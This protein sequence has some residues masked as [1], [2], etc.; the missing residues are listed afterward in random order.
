MTMAARTAGTPIKKLIIICTGGSVHL[1]AIARPHPIFSEM[2]KMAPLPSF[3]MV[4]SC[5][6]QPTGSVC[7]ASASEAGTS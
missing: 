1:L 6:N 3:T 5:T 4:R 2:P 7:D